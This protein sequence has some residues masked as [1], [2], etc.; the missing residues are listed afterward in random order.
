MTTNLQAA[1]EATRRSR[2]ALSK[3]DKDSARR[4]AEKSASLAPKLEE[5][6]LLLAATSRPQL[7]LHYLERA[8]AINPQS[9]AAQKGVLWA[10]KRL[11]A[12]VEITQPKPAIKERAVPPSK[13]VHGGILQIHAIEADETQPI[14][15]AVKSVHETQPNIALRPR[16][17]TQRWQQSMPA[18][19][20]TVVLVSLVWAFMPRISSFAAA[21]Q[22]TPTATFS[23]WG[24]ADIAKP[25]YTPTA[26]STP[27]PTLTPT[28]TFTPTNTP[29]PTQT[30]RPAN[31]AV[32]ASPQENNVVWGQ[33]YVLVDISDQHL[34]AYQGDTLVYSFVASTGMNNATATGSFSV[35]N[36][37]PSAYGATWNIWMPSW[38]GI[39]WAGTMQN[40]IHALPIMANGATLWAGYLGTP[41][42]YGCVVLGSY[43]AQLLYNWVDIGTPVDIRW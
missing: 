40:G 5:P 39:Y 20:V 8:L 37:I 23:H 35:L 14:K 36:K 7:S 11:E 1:K 2:A 9:K 13:N 21:M 19:L 38:L 6:W 10:N 15:K 16:R 29:V 43:E 33:K 28:P 3:G 41:I 42:S 34:Y 27:T 30:A 26:T 17:K 12:Q 25:T 31:T 22:A 4:W 24:E 32:P 18:L